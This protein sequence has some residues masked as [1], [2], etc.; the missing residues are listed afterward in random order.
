MQEKGKDGWVLSIGNGLTYCCPETFFILLRNLHKA[1]KGMGWER[2]FALPN[3]HKGTRP[4]LNFMETK[5]LAR[6]SSDHGAVISSDQRL[7]P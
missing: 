5:V 4:G 6:S 1:G 2:K 7:Q 3:D